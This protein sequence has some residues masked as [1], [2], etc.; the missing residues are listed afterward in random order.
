MGY[1]K[2]YQKLINT[3]INVSPQS[4]LKRTLKERK[5][6]ERRFHQSPLAGDSD[7]EDGSSRL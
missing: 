7:G 4:H 6:A 2:N 3:V 5:S 1:F